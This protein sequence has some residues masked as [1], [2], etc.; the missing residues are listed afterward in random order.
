M[1]RYIIHCVNCEIFNPHPERTKTNEYIG[2]FPSRR[3]SFMYN[4][5]DGITLI[6]FTL[7]TDGKY[8]AEVLLIMETNNCVYNVVIDGEGNTSK[9]RLWK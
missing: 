5:G 1:N 4:N 7:R 6:N 8:Q 3:T 2:T 9:A